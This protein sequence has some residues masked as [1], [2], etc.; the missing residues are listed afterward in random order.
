MVLTAVFARTAWVYRS[1]RAYRAVLLEAGHFCQTFCL[2]AT[3]IRLAPFCTGAF[4]EAAIESAL[5]VDGVEESV[6]YVA[7][8]G[9][10]PR[11]VTWA[12]LPAG[13]SGL[14]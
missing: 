12:P 9:T 13:E 11:D 1:A 14:E 7:G 6:V 10:R 2:A 3:E 4:S 8:V 5:G